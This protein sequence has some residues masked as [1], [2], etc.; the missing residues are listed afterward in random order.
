MA[1]PFHWFSGASVAE[2]QRQ[3]GA[4]K[5]PRLEVHQDGAD[6]RLYVYDQA[7]EADVATTNDGINESHVCPPIC[8]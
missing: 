2:L 1:R 6:M 3:L 8:P 5:D 4:A 7:T